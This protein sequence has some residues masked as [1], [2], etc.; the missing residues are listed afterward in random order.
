MS[1]LKCAKMRRTTFI[2]RVRA[3]PVSMWNMEITAKTNHFNVLLFS[4]TSPALSSMLIRLIV[5]SAFGTMW[6]TQSRTGKT[7]TTQKKNEEEDE[8]NCRPLECVYFIN[9]L[10]HENSVC[11]LLCLSRA[12]A[13]N[14]VLS[15]ISFVLLHSS[16]KFLLSPVIRTS[17]C[18]FFSENERE[19]TFET[20]R[21]P[22][23]HRGPLTLQWHKE[24]HAKWK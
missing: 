2:V 22:G 17:F 21:N 1:N 15:P 23:P 20:K 5:H 24:I 7:K 9:D 18:I 3:P 12:W 11:I 19:Q 4:P 8:M 13:R 16:D 14:P 6:H 10:F